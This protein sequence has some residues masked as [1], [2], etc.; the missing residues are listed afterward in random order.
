MSPARQVAL[1]HDWLTGMRGGE[2]VLERLCARYP[3]APIHTLIHNAPAVSDRINAH[4][5]HTSFLQRIPGIARTYR[6]FLPLYPA[7]VGTMPRPRADLLISSSHC[8]IKSLRTRT[9]TRHLC[10][11]FTPM[12]YAWTFYTEYFGRNPL[13]ALLVKPIL[14]ALR[15]WDRKTAG[16]VDRFVAI[17]GHVRDRIRRFY[18]READVVYPPVDTAYWTPQPAPA[19]HAGYDLVVSALVPYKRVDL[20]VRAYTRAGLPL[21]VVG[22]GRAY[23][24]LCALAGPTVTMLGRQPDSAL[25]DLYRRCR[26]LVFPG[27]EDFGIVP[28]EAQACGRPVVAYGVGGVRETVRPGETG[29]FF[30]ER[31][32]DALLDAVARAAAARWDPAA[33]RAHAEQFGPA[34]FES[35]LDACIEKLF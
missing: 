16:R 1:A 30:A 12:R 4:P 32:E 10:Y 13:K 29:V 28:L 34:A 24:A 20:A 14:A 33:I 19:S 31:G 23:T 17:S 5:V 22:T 7:A 15:R 26:C 11:C 3:G 18:G 27:E 35:G 9:G 2:R 8:A 6:N 25:R 21:K